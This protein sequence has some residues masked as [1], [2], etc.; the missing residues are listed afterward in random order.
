MSSDLKVTNIKH[1]SSGSNNLVLGSDGTTTV[2]GALTA[3]GGIKVADG[4]NIGSASDT[5]AMSI[6]SAGVITTP[7]RPSFYAYG[8]DSSD[9]YAIVNSNYVILKNV[10]TIPAHNIGSHYSTSTGKFTTPVAGIYFFQFTWYATQT[11]AYEWLLTDGTTYYN[12]IA[13]TPQGANQQNN[14]VFSGKIDAN[15]QIGIQNTAGSDR[16]I[17]IGSPVHTT[18]SGF[19][20]G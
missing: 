4:G 20:V 12:R 2:S 9:A 8:Q 3:S 16:S 15:K 13:Y 1:A 14:L 11:L 19:L 10:S 7:A 5:D 18:F 6:S 17:Y